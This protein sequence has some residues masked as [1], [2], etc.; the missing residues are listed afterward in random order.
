MHGKDTIRRP[1]KSYA[2]LYLPAP[3]WGHIYKV[4][5]HACSRISVL[6]K[7][8]QFAIDD[9]RDVGP[10]RNFEDKDCKIRFNANEPLQNSSMQKEQC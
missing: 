2:V 5:Y 10:F 4:C 7:G 3:R 6:R 1:Q 9:F 8:C